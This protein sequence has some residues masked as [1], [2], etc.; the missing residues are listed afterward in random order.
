DDMRDALTFIAKFKDCDPCL[1]G[2]FMHIAD[3]G[4]ILDI[5]GF[6]P[7]ARNEMIGRTEGTVG[8]AE[9][10]PPLPQTG[11]AGSGAVMHEMAVNIEKGEAVIALKDEMLLPD[12][13]EHRLLVLHHLPHTLLSNRFMK[14]TGGPISIPVG[15]PAFIPFLRAK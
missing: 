14:L 13:I 15:R 2:I 3:P 8:A 6:V 1:A 4:E 9:F 11:K 5:L 7:E 12:F 10:Q